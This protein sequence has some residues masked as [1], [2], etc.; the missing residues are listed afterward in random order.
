MNQLPVTEADLHAYVDGLLPQSRRTE[1]ESYLASRPAEAERI[2][3][4]REQS[5]RLRALFEPVLDE[6]MP[7][8]LSTLTAPPAP[9]RAHLQRYA[10]GLA[11]ALIGGVAGWVLNGQTQSGTMPFR[12]SATAPASARNVTALAHQAAIAH[13]VY[14]PDVRRPVEIDA[15]QEDQLVAW[16][17]KRIGTP[18]RPPKLGKLGYELI[19]G[20][21]LPGE[22][23]PVAQFMYHDGTGRRLTLYVS[24]EQTHNK[25]TG[26]R[27][28][29][30]GPVN[31]FYWIDGK[32]GYA[33]SAGMDK[34]E[35]ARVA[36]AV[37]E[38]LDKPG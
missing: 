27:F 30:E 14:S 33:L 24:T 10:A 1:I 5:A 29:Q 2:N 31:V 19:G 36:N 9:A 16:L 11:I 20:R 37:Y 13:A 3:A 38:Q 34:G 21:L 28:T 12:A 8:Q 23:G 35:L 17:S 25:D 22:S 32:F 4:Y 18:I 6:P 15:D 7:P 26:F